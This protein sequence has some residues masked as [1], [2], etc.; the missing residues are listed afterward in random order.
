MLEWRR[1]SDPARVVQP[2]AH[3]RVTPKASTS[4]A[5]YGSELSSRSMP[6]PRKRARTLS[7]KAGVAPVSSA[8]A[9]I[10]SSRVTLRDLIRS[11]PSSPVNSCTESEAL[12]QRRFTMSRLATQSAIPTTPTPRPAHG[13]FVT[14]RYPP[15]VSVPPIG[16]AR[17]T[18][19]RCVRPGLRRVLDDR[20]AP[21]PLPLRARGAR[22]RRRG[23]GA[24][25]SSSSR[26]CAA[27][28]PM[29]ATACTGSSWT[30]WPTTPRGSPAR[31][32]LPRVRRAC[33][34]RRQGVARG[35]G[36]PR[37]PRRHRRVPGV[38]PPAHGGGRG[39]PARRPRRSRGRE[40][41]PAASG[42][43]PR[44]PTAYAFRRHLQRRLPQHLD[45]ASRARSSTGRPA[46]PDGVPRGRRVALAVGDRARPAADR[47]RGEVGRCP[48]G[49]IA[50][51]ERLAAFVEQRLGSYAEERNEPERDATSGLSPYLHFGHLSIHELL[52]A[53]TAREGW[54]PGAVAS[55][56]DGRREGWWG[57]S[58]SA[59][60]FLDQAVTWRELGYNFDAHR[61]AAI[62]S[63]RADWA[64]RTLAEHASDPRPHR[65]GLAEL[66]A[67]TT[68][69]PLWNA[70]QTQL[71]AKVA[72]RTTSACCGGRRSSNGRTG[73]DEALEAMFELND[74][75]ALDGRDPNSK[76]G[77]C[78]T[79]GGTT[80]RGGPS[81]NLRHRPLHEL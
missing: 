14:G 32:R 60:A 15:R 26:L 77:I 8:R 64:R 38:L 35:A 30:G 71:V 54:S 76:S 7:T 70:A 29:R 6:R 25:R 1:T 39:G 19:S 13:E 24:S 12:L 45:R 33:A 58:A 68:H 27:T 41:A 52:L 53:V 51:R 42:R 81:A 10:D 28:T 43:G 63:R 22:S 50:A 23:A 34:G 21:D 40:R 57:L 75:Y 74:R 65:Y 79:L 16:S 11:T 31:D 73:P 37:L 47:P 46:P 44:L 72:F 17:R 59:E 66:E 5:V 20:G 61:P 62:G 56:A 9:A 49:E 55:D 2:V 18:G 36:A 3:R 80:A 69:D 67:G 78:W 4:A 48:R